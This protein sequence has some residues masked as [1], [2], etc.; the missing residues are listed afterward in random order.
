MVSEDKFNEWPCEGCGHITDSFYQRSPSSRKPG[1]RMISHWH[2]RQLSQRP[3]LSHTREQLL[4]CR[5]RSV[6]SLR[7]GEIAGC[8]SS[9]SR[10]LLKL[11]SMVSYD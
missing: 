7:C 6:G 3:L 5:T 4:M 2:S 10:V 8:L 1:T 11:A 9:R